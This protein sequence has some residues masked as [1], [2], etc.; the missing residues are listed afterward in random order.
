MQ[1]EIEPLLE[2]GRTAVPV[3]GVLK[4]HDIVFQEQILF[5]RYVYVKVGVFFV[6]VVDVDHFYLLSRSE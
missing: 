1:H 5:A 3:E 2:Q 4:Y 6:E